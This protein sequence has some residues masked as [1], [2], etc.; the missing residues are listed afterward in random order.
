[1]N[2][3]KSKIEAE[4]DKTVINSVDEKLGNIIGCVEV[5]KESYSAAII[6]NPVLL[7]FGV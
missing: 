4:L 7:L 1:M 6:F 5:S 2:S 3:V